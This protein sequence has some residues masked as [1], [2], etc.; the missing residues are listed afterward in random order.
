M[1]ID[2][3]SVIKRFAAYFLDEGKLL[4][5]AVGRLKNFEDPEIMMREKIKP[6]FIARYT[7]IPFRQGD[8]FFLS[9]YGLCTIERIC[10]TEEMEETEMTDYNIVLVFVKQQVGITVPS[11]ITETIKNLTRSLRKLQMFMPL[12]AYVELS[13]D[14]ESVMKTLNSEDLTLEDLA[15]VSKKTDEITLKLN[16]YLADK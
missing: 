15:R 10:F 12:K 16:E 11:E 8:G 2:E 7:S 1:V 6:F 3:M 9:K 13:D 5:E 14:L 4:E